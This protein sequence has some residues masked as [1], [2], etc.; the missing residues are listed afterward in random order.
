MAEMKKLI[1]K[2]DY[3]RNKDRQDPNAALKLSDDKLVDR[4]FKVGY[5]VHTIIPET[6]KYTEKNK[7]DM[8]ANL[9]DICICPYEY[10][11]MITS[12]N[13]KTKSKIFKVQQHNPV[14]KIEFLKSVKGR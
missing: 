10:L 5:V 14:E 1:P 8:Y 3:V 12:G 9:I 2:N 6:T 4:L 7:V 13:V 11:F